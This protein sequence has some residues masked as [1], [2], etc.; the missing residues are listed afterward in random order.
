MYL[1]HYILPFVVYFL[2]LKREEKR[3]EIKKRKKKSF[4]DIPRGKL[5]L[6]GLLLGNLIDLDHLW[7]R[8]VGKVW[9]FDSACINFGQQC[10]FGF[11]PLHSQVTLVVFSAFFIGSF[12]KGRKIELVGWL[13][14]GAV[15]NLILDYVHLITGFGI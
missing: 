2:F 12:H 5:I 8:L 9:W 13:A 7:Y 11:Y 1:L 6:Y 15:I 10:S 14:L 3:G 4:F